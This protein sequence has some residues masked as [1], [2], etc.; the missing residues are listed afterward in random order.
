LFYS[1]ELRARARAALAAV[2]AAA[3]GVALGTVAVSVS[4]NSAQATTVPPAGLV[5][6]AAL[7]AAA[8]A[9]PAAPAVPPAPQ[10]DLAQAAKA[11][12]AAERA[13]HDRDLECLTEAVYFEARGE[14][15]AGQAAVAQV[16]MNR[17]N[18]PAFPKTVCGVV[19]QGAKKRGCQF[20]FACDGR[21]ERVAESAAW[22][23]AQK[24]AAR[25]L[26]G[27]MVAE[28]GQATHFHT[29]QV[30]PS[31]AP[32]LRRTAQVGM[33]VFYK[34]NSRG[35]GGGGYVQRAAAP[36]KVRYT[37][38][39]S[40]DGETP[41]VKLTGHMPIARNVD[42]AASPASQTT[43]APAAAEPIF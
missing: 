6:R 12:R 4:L 31:W 5:A 41:S 15:K 42:D 35:G 8:I 33:H 9:V 10:A 40:S 29:V 27:V 11:A 21:A 32:R 22:N 16:V 14:S 34:F 23:R 17:V 1:T 18:H 3:V 13:E 2:G 37:R 19:Y 25:A 30:H 7:P 26:A 36:E 38:L 43:P 28:I 20:S 39:A 24:V